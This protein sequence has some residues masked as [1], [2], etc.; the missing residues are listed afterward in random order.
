MTTAVLDVRTY[1]LVPGAREEFDRILREEAM[2]LVPFPRGRNGTRS[3]ARSTAAR[4][5]AS[6]SMTVSAP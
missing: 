1:Q 4:N 6:A 2:P 3:S 5:G